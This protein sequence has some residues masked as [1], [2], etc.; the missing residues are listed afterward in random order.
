[1]LRLYNW[2]KIEESSSLGRERERGG[3]GCVK[4]SVPAM[5]FLP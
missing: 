3:P 2:E 4:A 5:M 1:M